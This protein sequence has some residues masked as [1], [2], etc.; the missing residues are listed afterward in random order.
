M[1]VVPKK[2]T[3]FDSSEIR[4]ITIDK[5]AVLELLQENL[6]ENQATY[7]EVD[8]DFIARSFCLTH[9]DPQSEQLTYALLPV[10]D[11]QKATSLDFNEINKKVGIT[12][13]SL[14][15]PNRFRKLKLTKDLFKNMAEND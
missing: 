5:N 1:K 4:V 15:K 11:I 2:K 10:Q 14:F 3:S 6:C 12:T 7:F 13:S 9:W 8:D